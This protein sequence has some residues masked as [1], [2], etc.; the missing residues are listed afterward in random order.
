MPEY[1]VDWTLSS[2]DATPAGPTII[3]FG[4]GTDWR[5]DC[6]NIDH[7]PL[8]EPDLIL[9]L[10][11]PLPMDVPLTTRRF[12]VQSLRANSFDGL[13]ANDLLE[14]L[15]NLTTF[16]TGALNLLKP[17]C[18]F[19]IKVPYDLS[20][21][22]WQDPT[23]VR[24]FNEN[25]WIYF[26]D[27]HWYLGWDDARFDLV[28]RTFLLTSYGMTLHNKGI[29]EENLLRLPRVVDSMKVVLKKRLLTPLEQEAMGEKLKK[30]R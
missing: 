22:A 29:N 25:S 6:L 9:D 2:G 7:N 12:G 13:L 28:E 10:N 5:E 4:C 21:G 20:L 23:H 19:T 8:L 1:P 26:T 15:T 24:A 14:H 11:Q 17:G 18:D 27:Y 30:N 3:N 16:M